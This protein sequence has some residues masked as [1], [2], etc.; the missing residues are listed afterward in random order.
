MKV[1][2]RTTL[3]ASA[4][5][6]LALGAGAMIY[7]QTLPVGIQ[8]S[9]SYKQGTPAHKIPHSYCGRIQSISSSTL[10]ISRTHNNS[11]TQTI[12]LSHISVRAGWYKL[13]LQ[14][15]VSQEAVTVNQTSS[16]S[17]VLNL[18]PVARGKLTL[19]NGHWMIH[20]EA[21]TGHPTMEGI[22]QMTAGT[23]VVVYGT[24]DG[25]Q[26]VAQVVQLRPKMVIGT[27]STNQSGTLSVTTKK[28]G[29]L[30]YSYSQAP[31]SGQLGKIAVGHK[32]LLGINGT[33]HQVLFAHAVEH[34]HWGQIAKTLTHNVYGKL[35]QTSASSLSIQG[36]WGTQ[37]V[38]L[39]PKRIKVLW[40]KHP[41]T[42]LSQVPIGSRVML[43]QSRHQWILHVM[44]THK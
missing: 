35:T 10:T 15:L 21:V 19:N 39:N 25:S 2:L 20:K 24:R 34:I 17:W 4:S 43:H 31:N 7:S 6:V 18:H 29:S 40:I 28:V 37:Q 36:K 16:S 27:V 32:V 41:K 33:T 38:H 30:Q 42:S 5:S 8:Y 11:S 12:P 26:I 23:P 1:S 14:T 9:A 13:P 22:T 3:V 44:P